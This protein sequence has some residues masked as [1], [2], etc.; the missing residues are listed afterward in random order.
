MKKKALIGCIIAIVVFVIAAVLIVN[1]KKV[2]PVEV[3]ME[4]GV[5][6]QTV[7]LKDIEFSQ[8]TKTYEGGITT[9]K[10][11]MHN[12]SNNDKSL[13]INITLKDSE[14]IEVGNMRQT[15]ENVE[16]GRDKILTT[17]ITGDYSHVAEITFEVIKD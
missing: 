17:G 13:N 12:N 14:G 4:N 9:I 16:K 7:V 15:I 11:K 3:T 1:N 8:I 10:A 2:K 6:E 5:T